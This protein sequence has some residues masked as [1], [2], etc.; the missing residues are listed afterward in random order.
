MKPRHGFTLI[1]VSFATIVLTLGILLATRFVTAIYQQLMPAGDWSGL[2]R[3]MLAEELLT[4]QAEGL[5][6]LRVISPVPASNRLVSGPPGSRYQLGLTLSTAPVV[7]AFGT[8]GES[9]HQQLYY[10]DLTVT[11]NGQTVGALTLST[12]RSQVLGQHEKI[13]L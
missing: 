5:R 4:T 2:R 7:A 11:H 1:E 12:L 3:Y 9:A 13:G 6:A 10:V 8:T